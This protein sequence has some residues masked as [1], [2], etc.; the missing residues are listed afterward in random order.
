MSTAVATADW[1][2]QIELVKQ[3]CAPTAT[4]EEFKLMGHIALRYGLDPLL[5]QI[6]VIKYGDSPAQIFTGRD[7]FLSIAHRSGH[8]NGMNT[9]V[10]PVQMPIHVK[11]KRYNKFK[12][13]WNEFEIKRDWQYKAICT[14]YRK[15]AAYP[16]V[17]EVYEEEYTTCENL[18]LD[19]PRT[20]LGKVAE[21]QCLRKAFDITGL[22][23][24]EEMPEQHE[25]DVTP[26][27]DEKLSDAQRR[28]EE[29]RGIRPKPEPQPVPQSAPAPES[30]PRAEDFISEEL[31]A[32]IRGSFSAAEISQAL[33]GTGGD[34]DKL[35]YNLATI[36]CARE[37]EKIKEV[38]YGKGMTNGQ[39]K[40]HVSKHDF[41]FSKIKASFGQVP[42]VQDVARED[43]MPDD[44]M[45]FE[46]EK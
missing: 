19:K 12:R 31:Q 38:Y 42:T 26:P 39:V 25:R 14:I 46:D 10:E 23:S 41:S 20:M 15:D 36:F 33:V 9:S 4:N 7:G 35:L 32:R 40:A 37:A 45:K 34:E 28:F 13:E 2:S 5:K 3:I 22:Y 21:S 11:K 30:A 18:W 44:F 1:Q 24:P 27:K 8:F 43:K 17:V 16:F 29:E 6:W